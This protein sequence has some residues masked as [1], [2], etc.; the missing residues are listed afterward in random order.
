MRSIFR[1][2]VGW[3]APAPHPKNFFAALEVF[4]PPHKGEVKG[5]YGTKPCF[6][7][8]R[9]ISPAQSSAVRPSVFTVTSACSGSS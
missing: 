3:S 4:R 2:G 6:L 5:S 7:K 1:A 8:Y 9:T